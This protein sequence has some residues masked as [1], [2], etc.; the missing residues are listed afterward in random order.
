M[1]RLNPAS[2]RVSAAPPDAPAQQLDRRSLFGEILDWILAP[3]LIIWPITIGISYTVVKNI[4]DKPFDRSLE[5]NIS[6]ISATVSVQNQ[7]IVLGKSF[8]TLFQSSGKN[9][10]YYAVRSADMQLIGGDPHITFPID[11]TISTPNTVHFSNVDYQGNTIRVAYS[12]INLATEKFDA[13]AHIFIGENLERRAQLTSDIIKGVILP[14]LLIFPLI[15][16]FVWLALTRGLLPLR[17]L[18]KS[19]SARPVQDFSVIE[20]HEVPEEIAPLINSMNDLLGQLSKMLE[21]QKN[22]IANAAHQMKTPLAGLRTQAELAQRLKNP[23]EINRSLELISLAAEQSSHLINQ[24]L[25]LARSE[26]LNQADSTVF[27]LVESAHNVTR[28]WIEKALDK[29]ID[30][31]VECDED[32]VLI[33]GLPL[34]LDEVLNNLIDNA[35]RYSPPQSVITVRLTRHDTHALLSVED[36]GAGMS[37]L[38][39]RHIFDRFYRVSKTTEGSG[40]GLSI[41]QEIINFHN[42][43]IT[44][45]AQKNDSGTVF[46]ITLPLFSAMKKLI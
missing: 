34:M 20:T 19:I 14:Q 28:N 26:N 1:T 16:G 25:L 46:Q 27:N 39:R 44:V 45:L 42:G 13:R 30:L 41:V 43:Q 9:Y 37:E 11:D 35:I 24:L 18:Q 32:T 6:R 38:E 40:L 33:Q 5:E 23:S 21:S 2:V 10:F 31:G 29:S 15:L 36:N 3:L 22:F 12:S 7:G 8:N 17:R 4:A